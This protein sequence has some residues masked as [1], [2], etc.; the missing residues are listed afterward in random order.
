[1]STYIADYGESY[2]YD[3]KTKGQSVIR[4]VRNFI[5]NN[6]EKPKLS[7]QE[8]ANEVGISPSYLSDLYSKKTSNTI[9]KYITAIRIRA[10]KH[11]LGCTNKPIKTICFSCGFN[12]LAYFY[13]VFKRAEKVTPSKFRKKF[14]RNLE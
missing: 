8:I 3:K 1:M 4:R 5:H 14:S 7:L 12:S 9:K 13:R 2:L 10:A 6:Y 11:M